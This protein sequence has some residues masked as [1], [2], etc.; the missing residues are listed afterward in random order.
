MFRIVRRLRY[1]V[2]RRLATQEIA[3]T[4]AAEARATPQTRRDDR[5]DVDDYL[6]SWKP[7]HPGPAAEG[8]PVPTRPRRR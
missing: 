8:R 4:N 7:T 5:H 1:L 6:R 2:L 3:R